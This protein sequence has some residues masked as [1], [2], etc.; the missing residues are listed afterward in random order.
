[1]NSRTISPVAGSV[2]W[3]FGPSAEVRPFLAY[4]ASLEGGDVEMM[5][6]STDAALSSADDLLF[7]S[8]EHDY[9]SDLV[10]HTR[11]VFGAPL[12]AL[13]VLVTTLTSTQQEEIRTTDSGIRRAVRRTGV[14]I[15]D[16]D[17]YR[18][19]HVLELKKLVDE[20]IETVA[21]VPD[22]DLSLSLL[23]ASEDKKSPVVDA[24][25]DYVADLLL[26]SDS[27][28][29]GMDFADLSKHGLGGHFR[30]FLELAKKKAEER[31]L[32]LES[33][34]SFNDMQRPI[35]AIESMNRQAKKEALHAA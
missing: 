35:A 2:Y 16:T 5:M 4:A 3:V 17:E 19:D 7:R 32:S 14:L 28:L 26:K 9:H 12:S 23:I 25:T 15:R 20:F 34:I 30:E 11:L 27:H 29:F 22:I 31:L 21:A 8:A 10:V 1:M 24:A 33:P 18:W 6:V 13:K